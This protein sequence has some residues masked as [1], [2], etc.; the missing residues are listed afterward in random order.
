MSSETTTLA[1]R[2]RVHRLGEDLDGKKVVVAVDDQAGKEVAFA[3]DHAI[4]I[5]VAHHPFAIGDC[6]LNSLAHQAGQVID[7]VRE[8][9]RM[10]ICEELL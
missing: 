1:D 7:R 10:A 5:G 2:L 4:G 3:E 9:M 8:I 6:V